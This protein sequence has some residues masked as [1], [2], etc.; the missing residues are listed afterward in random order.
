[1]IVNRRCSPVTVVESGGAR[2]I[3]VKFDQN[4]NQ[5]YNSWK[6]TDLG[7]AFWNITINIA[8]V[9][10]S[11]NLGRFDPGEGKLFKMEPVLLSGG[12]LV[13]DETISGTDEITLTDTL[14]TNGFN[15]T[16]KK[17]LSFTSQIHQQLSLTAAL[18]LQVI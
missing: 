18:L 2:Y 4:T 13:S 9:N 14:F 7:D 15:L 8:G 10:P 3:T 12:E 16:M 11:A 17:G 6:L 1:M 5:N